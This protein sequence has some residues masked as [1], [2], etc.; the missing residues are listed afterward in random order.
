MPARGRAHVAR[1][2][3]RAAYAPSALPGDIPVGGRTRN[4]VRAQFSAAALAAPLEQPAALAQTPVRIVGQAVPLADSSL[5]EFERAGGR[6]APRDEI[7]PVVDR[8]PNRTFSVPIP[9]EPHAPVGFAGTVPVPAC[10]QP[11][12]QR[13][14]EPTGPPPPRC[15]GRC[16]GGY[17]VP[18]TTF[19]FQRHAGD[20]PRSASWSLVAQARQWARRARNRSGA[21]ARRAG[22]AACGRPTTDRTVGRFVAFAGRPLS[23]TSPVRGAC[24]PGMHR[25]SRAVA[26]SRSAWRNPAPARPIGAGRDRSMPRQRDK[27]GSVYGAF[28]NTGESSNVWKQARTKRA[29]EKSA[30]PLHGRLDRTGG[31]GQVHTRPAIHRSIVRTMFALQ[32]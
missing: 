22:S 18:N 24:R 1:P 29:G 23:R 2:L 13:T 16:R 14:I 4:A 12:T 30:R 9:Q 28:G 8:L 7:V 21:P 5:T 10:T 20:V 3:G 27:P 15:A 25:Q 17:V 31:Q 32:P 6:H 11:R 19:L 26:R